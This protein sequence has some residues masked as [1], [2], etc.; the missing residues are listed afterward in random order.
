[1]ISNPLS[2]QYQLNP[3]LNGYMH[4]FRERSY[5][6]EVSKKK[7]ARRELA[8][9]LKRLEEKHDLIEKAHD[10]HT[11]NDILHHLHSLLREYGK[12]LPEDVRRTLDDIAQSTDT[13]PDGMTHSYK[14]LKSGIEQAISSLPSVATGGISS[15]VIIGVIIAGV[16]AAV[17]GALAYPYFTSVQ[18]DIVNDGCSPIQIPSVSNTGILGLK[19]P[20]GSIYAGGKGTAD[21]PRWLNI[22]IHSGGG[23]IIFDVPGSQL[24]IDRQKEVTSVLFNG[25]PLGTLPMDLGAQKQNKLVISCR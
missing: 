18:L 10:V 21:I 16:A 15:S 8:A 13:S 14:T 23:D 4:K 17:G 11:W 1:M 25:S 24:K 3:H 7:K 2:Y 22:K 6:A 12:D 20:Q 5:M 9:F 19:L